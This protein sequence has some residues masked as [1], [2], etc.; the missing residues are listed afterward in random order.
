MPV[1]A[2]T[3]LYH[4][5]DVML[6][7]T[8]WA[9]MSRARRRMCGRFARYTPKRQIAE[10]FDIDEIG[11]L[12]DLPQRYNIAL[13]KLGAVVRQTVE[14]KRRLAMLCW[15]LIP[16]W[17]SNPSAGAKTFNART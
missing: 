17:A 12:F 16:A 5:K 7:K 2:P 1:S 9:E 4:I 13:T 8:G 6:H 10:E 3:E 11:Y 14:R 15:G